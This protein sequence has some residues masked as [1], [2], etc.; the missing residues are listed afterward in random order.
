MHARS[1]RREPVESLDCAQ[2]VGIAV[3]DDPAFKAGEKREHRP[4]VGQH[5]PDERRESCAGRRLVQHGEKFDAQTLS[6]PGVVDYHS[7]LSFERAATGV[8]AMATIRDPLLFVC[9][10]DDNQLVRRTRAALDVQA[11]MATAL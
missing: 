6:L 1:R 11:D 10:A 3:G 9:L 8:C 5:E 7:E 2:Q 4:V